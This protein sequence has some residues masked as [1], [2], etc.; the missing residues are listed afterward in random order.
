MVAKLAVG[1][2]FSSLAL[3]LVICGAGCP[4]EEDA[5]PDLLHVEIQAE[6]DNVNPDYCMI[7]WPSSRYLVADS[8]TNTGWRVD[9]LPEAF[10]LNKED[11][12]LDVSPYNRQ[13]G[14]PPSAQ[15][16][17][18]FPGEL[19][20]TDLAF[21][22]DYGRSVAAD[23]PVVLLDMETGM[24]VPHF[25]EFDVRYDEPILGEPPQIMMYI[26]PSR[27][28]EEDRRYAVG[29][30]GL[31]YTDGGAVEASPVFAALRDGVITDAAQVEARRP[32]FEEIFAALGE[33][34][35]ER[36]SLIQAWDFH[37][38]SGEALWGD[39][40]AMRDDAMERIGD[41]GL[42]CTIETVTDDYNGETYRLVEGTITAPLY[43]DS[44]W[45][46]A[47]LVR[48]DD[49]LP[50][51]QRDH[52]VPFLATIPQSL[53]EPGA[54]PGRLLTNGHGFFDSREEIT[55]GWFRGWTNDAA[56]VAVATDWAGMSIDDV[57]SAATALA[58]VSKFPMVTERLMQG[59]INTLVL[60][61]TMAGVCSEED[62]FQID[63]QLVFDPDELYYQGTS[64]GS[65]MGATTMALS[66]DIER[67]VLHV[68]AGVYPLMESR[69]TNFN[70]LAR[71]WDI[72]A[73]RCPECGG[74]MRLISTVMNPDAV[75]AITAALACTPRPG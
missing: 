7:P 66:Q 11:Y 70:L 57:A 52:E 21:H 23:H 58:D 74:L 53:A 14:F 47:R 59:V 9:Y 33:A 18:M 68:G 61:R 55:Y 39:I 17:T 75:E 38:A 20:G 64:Q 67:A 60:T 22:D 5:G 36:S 30:R 44:E 28:L 12:P 62:A 6:C 42:G 41:A 26:R 40:L 16:I 71:T 31:T 69:S 1:I 13:D 8:T 2:L 35:A 46:P 3:G 65:I 48:G 25:A 50:A 4:G 29:I 34:G 54:A 51:Y 19:V 43:M 24:L 49:G 63:G 56:M 15:I 72:D 10:P 45:S 27:R 73:L 37:T 32:A